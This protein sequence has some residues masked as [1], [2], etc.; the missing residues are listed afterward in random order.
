ML[1]AWSAHA[2]DGAAHS[3]DALV[4][5]ALANNAELKAYE[6]EVLAATGQRTQAGFSKVPR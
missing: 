6:A 3:V 2:G 5:S 4:T 1:V